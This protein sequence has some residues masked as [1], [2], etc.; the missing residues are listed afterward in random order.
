[1]PETL[2]GA[3]IELFSVIVELPDAKQ[4]R[5]WV[6]MFTDVAWVTAHGLVEGTEYKKC[7]FGNHAVWIRG[8]QVGWQ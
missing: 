1:M 2:E 7:H 8:D 6:S 3:A 5:T 4:Y